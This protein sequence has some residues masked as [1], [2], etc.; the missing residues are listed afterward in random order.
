MYAWLWRHL[1]FRRLGRLVAVAVLG[2]IVAVLLWRVV[3]PFL[4]PILLPFDDVQVDSVADQSSNAEKP[5][6]SAS[7]T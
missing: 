5:T 3:F 4:E 7:P 2:G 1:P 6:R